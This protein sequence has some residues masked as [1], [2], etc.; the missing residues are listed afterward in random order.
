MREGGRGREREGR[1]HSPL[2]RGRRVFVRPRSR[3]CLCVPTAAYEGKEGSRLPFADAA[4]AF[5]PPG[6]AWVRYTE[7]LRRLSHNL[8][9]VDIFF[10]KPR[11]ELTQKA[12]TSEAKQGHQKGERKKEGRR[13]LLAGA[14]RGGP[15]EEGHEKA[16]QGRRRAAADR[17]AIARRHPSN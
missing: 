7:C 1:E 16:G 4:A 2:P 8:R 11:L 6:A 12:E 15:G 5:S 13:K 17:Q 9:V 3:L 10:T 14:L